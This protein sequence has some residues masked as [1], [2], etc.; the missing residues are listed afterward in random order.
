MTPENRRYEVRCSDE[1]VCIPAEGNGVF[2]GF[3]CWSEAS[4]A[5]R[6]QSRVKDLAYG[7][8]D[9][10]QERFVSPHTG[11]DVVI[12]EDPDVTNPF[13]PSEEAKEEIHREE[14]ARAAYYYYDRRRA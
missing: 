12:K 7:V 13:E 5:A 3:G 8:W 14:Q 10:N 6:A 1:R 4:S 11:D 9:T 2:D